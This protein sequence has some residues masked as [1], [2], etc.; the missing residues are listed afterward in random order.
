M[1]NRKYTLTLVLKPDLSAEASKEINTKVAE[2][3]ERLDGKVV[4][5]ESLGLKTLAYSIKRETQASFGKF[6][7]ELPADRINALKSELEKTRSFLRIMID[8]D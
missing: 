2:A 1:E 6:S 4:K 7:L 8:K 3:V 5:T